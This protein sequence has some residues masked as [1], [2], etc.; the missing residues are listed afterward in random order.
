MNKKPGKRKN[1]KRAKIIAK[2]SKMNILK[3]QKQTY[4]D[5]IQRATYVPNLKDVSWF[6]RPWLQKNVSPIFSCKVGQ[7][8][9]VVMK[10]KLDMSCHLLNVYSKFQIDISK[11]AEKKSGK[12]GRVGKRTNVRTESW[13]GT[14][15]PFFEWVY[16]N[17]EN[18]STKWDMK[19]IKNFLLSNHCGR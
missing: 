15:R 16:K 1:P 6:M 12:L 9:P 13:H 8:D 5:C 7:S 10:L 11:H 18:S 4:V 3:K 17:E 2:I 19:R 14:I